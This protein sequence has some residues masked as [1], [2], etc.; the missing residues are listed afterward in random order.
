[1]G[2]VFRS[3]EIASG[4]PVAWHG[5]YLFTVASLLVAG[6][7]ARWRKATILESGI[8]AVAGLGAFE[9]LYAI[10]Y[11][12]ST[13]RP[14]LLIPGPTFPTAGWA[15]FGTWFLAELLVASLLLVS[16][17][18]FGWDPPTAAVAVVFGG[19]LV[20]WSVVLH[21]SYPPYGTSAAVYAI[22]TIAEVSGTALGPLLVTSRPRPTP[23]WVFRVWSSL[24]RRR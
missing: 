11:S 15:G 18:R 17:E 5:I 14:G 19:A 23:S 7:V 9:A 16:W 8:L 1:M 2:P 4:V 3:D 12:F 21:W 10:A 22:N 6:V 20:I 13:G 24:N